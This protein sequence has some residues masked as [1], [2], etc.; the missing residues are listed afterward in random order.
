M[1]ALGIGF[2]VSFVL[3]GI[4]TLIPSV[5][6]PPKGEELVSDAYYFTDSSLL[7]RLSLPRPTE[8]ILR[9]L[10]TIPPKGDILFVG[11]ENSNASLTFFLLS[12]LAWPRPVLGGKVDKEGRVATPGSYSP[13]AIYLYGNP[14]EP[15][16]DSG[17]KLG[18][19]I[20]VRSR[21]GTP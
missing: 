17:E 13:A 8:K 5:A 4:W 19:M 6:I 20:L 15:L 2:V 1:R 3:V 12:S 11:P 7:P 10:Q 16:G 21:G 14:S 18:Q 9:S